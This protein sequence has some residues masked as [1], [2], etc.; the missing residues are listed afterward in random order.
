MRLWSLHPN[1]LD[2]RG[3]TAVWREG[4]LAR[5]VLL[6]Q[7]RGYRKHP[8]LER[9]RGTVNP[10]ML[11]DAFL[12][13][14]CD[15]AAARGYAFDRT[16][17]ELREGVERLSVTAGQ[18]VYEKGHLLSKLLTRDRTRFDL[19]HAA[20]FPLPHPLFHV[21]D[22]DVEPWERVPGSGETQK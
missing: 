17:L 22:G 16:K 9:F 10:V 5:K 12:S 3:L 2:T 21:I 13:A 6:G 20:P 15:E 8:Q 11:I 14:I 1:Y 4:L 7:T 19:L 18:L